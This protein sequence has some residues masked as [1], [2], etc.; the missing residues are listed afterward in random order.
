MSD[1]SY[2]KRNYSVV[3]YNKT[4]P[5]QYGLIIEALKPVFGSLAT[6]YQHIGSTAV[7]GLAGK[8]TIDV[9]ITT[10]AEM[11]E[12][13]KLNN[14]L[15]K[16]GYEPLGGYVRDDAR[17]FVKVH[18]NERLVNIHVFRVDDLHVS[19]MIQLRDYLRAHPDTVTEYS[20]LKLSL[21]KKYPSQYDKYR[22]YK[23][24]WMEKLKRKIY[25]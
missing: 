24:A 25:K 18:N 1:Q 9:L 15:E 2:K 5:S 11:S 17:L 8:P 4:W 20:E 14:Q 12:I 19:E 3:P 13:D 21:F 10:K 16:M 23:D 22:E 7:P 6:D